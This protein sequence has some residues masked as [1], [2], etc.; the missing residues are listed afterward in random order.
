MK[1]LTRAMFVLLLVLLPVHSRAA[2]RAVIVVLD[3]MRSTEGFDDPTFQ[4]IPRMGFDLAPQGALARNCSNMG[5]TRTIPGHCAIGSGQYQDLPNDGSVRSSFPFLWEYYR[6]QTGAPELNT[7]IVTTKSKIN[8]LSYST[9]AGYGPGDSARVIGPTWDDV[10]TANQF[11]LDM[12]LN[13]PRV[14]LLNMGT[15]DMAAHAGIW[16]DYTRAIHTA[17]SLVALIWNRIESDPVYAGHTDLIVTGDH[18]R[19]A[20]EYGSWTDHGD[21]CP[22][23]RRIPLLCLGPDFKDGFVSWTFCQQIDICR[24][25]GQLIGVSTPLAGGR[26]LTELIQSPADVADA[27]TARSFLTVTAVDRTVRARLDLGAAAPARLGIF[28]LAG[29]RITSHDLTPGEEW[30]WAPLSGRVFFYRAEFPGE[31]PRRGPLLVR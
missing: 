24:T 4:Y 13:R 26:I 23:C 27:C 8:S 15:I 31:V 3:G 17:D 16:A 14:A 12:M 1:G 18:G 11:L 30:R 22:G 2:D 20:D 29:R 19:H 28:D 5:V 9:A 10:A 7:V 21:G 6:D 25:V